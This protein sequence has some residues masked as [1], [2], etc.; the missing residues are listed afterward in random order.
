M[1]ALAAKYLEAGP[2]LSDDGAHP[3]V[4]HSRF[5]TSHTLCDAQIESHHTA[6]QRYEL[7]PWWCLYQLFLPGQPNPPVPSSAKALASTAPIST[8]KAGMSWMLAILLLSSAILSVSAHG[9]GPVAAVAGGKSVKPGAE[10]YIQKHMASEHHINAF[11]LGSFFALHDLNRDGVWDRS[12][13]EAIYGVHHSNSIKHS[14]TAEIH[15]QKADTIVKEVF[16]RLDLNGD[17]MIAKSEFLHGGIDALPTFPEYG[18]GVLGH[19]Y[20]AESEFFV[21][22]EERYHSSPESQKEAAYNHPED[23]DHFRSHQKIENEEEERERK[24]EGLPS[25]AEEARLRADAAGRGEQYISEYERRQQ[26]RPEDQSFHQVEQDA[27]YGGYAED[28]AQR[29]Q[30]IFRGPGGQHVVKSHKEGTGHSQNVGNRFVGETQ[31]GYDQRKS[32]YNARLQAA[33]YFDQLQKEQKA[34]I[35]QAAQKVRKQSGESD[36]AFLRRLNEAKKDAAQRGLA[37]T[38]DQSFARP[39]EETKRMRKSA[40]KKVCRSSPVMH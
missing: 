14:P 27:Y 16:K 18:L 34:R 15:D 3:R 7:M 2:K 37:G 4:A 9:D 19:H 8:V 24:A 35:A 1:S 5:E 12:E 13:V 30:H 20:D 38:D 11:D 23:M 36:D 40:P 39:K 22:H 17:A 29:E 25:R 6:I 10:S 28:E 32:L 26:Q 31:Q 33:A 21:H